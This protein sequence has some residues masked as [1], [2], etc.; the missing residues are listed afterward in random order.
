MLFYIHIISVEKTIKTRHRICFSRASNPF[1]HCVLVALF[2]V[3]KILLFLVFTMINFDI[4]LTNLCST[5]FSSAMTTTVTLNSLEFAEDRSDFGHSFASIGDLDACGRH[6]HTPLNIASHWESEEYRDN[7]RAGTRI[8]LYE[9]ERGELGAGKF[10]K[11][12]LGRH[13]I[14][15]GGFF[16]REFGEFG[17]IGCFGGLKYFLK[18]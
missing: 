4:N 11:V 3:S 5:S 14:S 13:I 8:A 15:G 12:K 2:F 9:L 10:S 6:L 1:F 18:I 17:N 16:G 7:V